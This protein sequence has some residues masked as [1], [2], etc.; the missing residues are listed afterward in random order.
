MRHF[1]Q[2]RSFTSF[3]FLFLFLHLSLALL[4][5]TPHPSIFRDNG[6]I[7][8]MHCLGNVLLTSAYAAQWPLRTSSVQNVPASFDCAMRRAAYDYGRDLVGRHGSFE[9]LYY[10]LDLNSKDCH[11]DLE[12]KGFRR[13]SV[14]R[15]FC[16]KIITMLRKI[17][18]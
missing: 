2:T 7:E 6:I 10:A 5:P 15:G 11:A 17:T 4:S 14:V 16:Q 18:R 8:H 3:V 1:S 13:S 9:S 12:E